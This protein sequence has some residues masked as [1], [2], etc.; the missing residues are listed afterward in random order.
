MFDW[1]QNGLILLH[2]DANQKIN[3]CG[4]HKHFASIKSRKVMTKLLYFWLILLLPVTIPAQNSAELEK[5]SI[6]RGEQIVK[7]SRKAINSEKINLIGFKLKTKSVNDNAFDPKM[8]NVADEINVSLPDKIRT[9]RFIEEL[10]D[11]TNT[12][13][14]N[15]EKYKEISETDFF[16]KHTVKD[17]TNF[18]LN[19]Q[20]LENISNKLGKEKMGNF[21]GYVKHDPKEMFNAEIWQVFFPLLLIQPFEQNLK[22]KY[23]GKAKSDNRIANVVDVVGQNGRNYRLLFDS[24]TNYLLMTIESF[25]GND[26]DYENKYYYSSRELTENVL[27]PKKIKVE[28]KFTPTG[29]K[30]RIS[31]TNIDILE[32]KLNPEIKENI[33]EVK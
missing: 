19:S 22:F 1:H 5:N 25:K 21:K 23:V 10:G 8:R 31:Y 29:E 32:F 26:G 6:I 9:V 28:N 12:R 18:S 30:S 7:D 20:S 14:W 16:G 2:F 24:D 17:V 33:F 15:A 3:F 13:I 4:L 27:I 11:F